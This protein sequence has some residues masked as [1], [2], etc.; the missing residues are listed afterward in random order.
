MGYALFPLVILMVFAGLIA[1][2]GELAMST[3]GAGPVGLAETNADVAADRAVSYADACV[4]TAI[5]NP[6]LTGESIVAQLPLGVI[7]PHG[8][9][10]KID[11]APDGGRV[12][13]AW[14]PVVPGAIEKIRAVTDA[15]ETWFVIST[16]PG[17]AS[18]IVGGATHTVPAAV[19]F[20]SVLYQAE[21]RP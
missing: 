9:A 15:G 12:V 21:V 2:A 6:G 20:R 19:P 8:A 13:Y 7:A 16:A 18:G 1:Q 11:A 10:C 4:R 14:A 5:A 3:L 17:V